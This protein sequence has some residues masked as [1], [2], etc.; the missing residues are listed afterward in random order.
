LDSTPPLAARLDS[1]VTQW[2][3]AG[4]FYPDGSTFRRVHPKKIGH[5]HN[6]S[7]HNQNYAVGENKIIGP[8]H[9]RYSKGP[10]QPNVCS[11]PRV[12]KCVKSQRAVDLALNE[13]ERL[14]SARR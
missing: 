13:R 10:L 5:T 3:A 2:F 1:A 8:V 12:L 14:K 9:C 4:R 6:N 7:D 11:R